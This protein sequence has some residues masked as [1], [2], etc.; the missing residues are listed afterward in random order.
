MRVVISGATSSLGTALCEECV[1]Q[2]I[3]VLALVQPG[4][5]K[6]NRIPQSSLIDVIELAL[7]NY[8]EYV[9]EAEIIENK[10]DT[11][12]HFAWGATQGDAAREQVIPHA[13][14]IQYALDAVDLANRF[15]CRTFVG[16]GS[17]AEY[18]RTDE[19]L[20][21]ET[22]CHPE[23]PYGIAKLCAGQLTRIA[24]RNIGM[25]HIWPRILS[26]YGPNCQPQTIINYTITELLNGRSPKLSKGE[27]IWDFIYTGDV[28]RA[29]LLLADKGIDGEVYVIGSGKSKPLKEYLNVI[30]DLIA[31]DIELGLG[32]KEY[33]KNTVMHLSCDIR[34]IMKDTGFEPIVSF[35]EGINL[36][37]NWIVEQME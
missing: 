21:E 27:Q 10:Y 4:S 24:C 36:T 12:I 26:A 31:P 20:T 19:I 18:G 23:T 7:D 34:K 13:K 14:N 28:A 33:S 8:S 22:E 15:G 1:R 11:F 25:K 5:A 17:Q 37:K 9:P 2:N 3:Q 16:A 35:E 6:K 32:I 29:L 30:R